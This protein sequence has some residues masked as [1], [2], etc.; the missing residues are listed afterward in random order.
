MWMIG[1]HEG[2]V[3]QFEARMESFALEGEFL[4]A[5]GVKKFQR[6]MVKAFEYKAEFNLKGFKQ[7]VLAPLY[8]IDLL[9][10]TYAVASPERLLQLKADIEAD[11]PNA[12]T[13]NGY[14]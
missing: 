12:R 7:Q 5:P 3:E 6:I 4:K 13:K 14:K 1:I 11:F 9:R 2:L 10:C 8:V